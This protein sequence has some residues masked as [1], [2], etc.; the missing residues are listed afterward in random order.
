MTETKKYSVLFSCSLL[1]HGL[2]CATTPTRDQFPLE[3]SSRSEIPYLS[4]TAIR[5]CV[6]S[7][8]NE[9]FI[10]PTSI[11]PHFFPSCQFPYTYVVISP[12]T[13]SDVGI[14]PKNLNTHIALV[15]IVLCFIY[16]QTVCP[17]CYNMSKHV[18][19]M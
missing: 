4:F 2:P 12:T 13:K 18:S 17:L 16:T 19:C 10:S 6:D 15:I 8:K 7:P 3:L 11:P 14:S 5:D 1:S 9:V